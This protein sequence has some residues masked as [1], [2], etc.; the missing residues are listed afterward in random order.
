MTKLFPSNLMPKSQKQSETHKLTYRSDC[1]TT[2]KVFTSSEF[3][4]QQFD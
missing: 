2:Q 1:L 3:E 4:T